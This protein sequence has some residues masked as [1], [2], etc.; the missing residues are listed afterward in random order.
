MCFNDEGTHKLKK[1]IFHHLLPVV[2]LCYMNYLSFIL[3]Y[4]L[5]EK[6]GRIVTSVVSATMENFPGD[7][8]YVEAFAIFPS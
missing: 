5:R 8:L 3:K 6:V 1:Y 4:F 7:F 2:L